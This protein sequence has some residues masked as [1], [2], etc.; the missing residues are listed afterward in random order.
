MTGWLLAA[1]A[2][3]SA[4]GIAFEILLMRL[5]SI[6]QWHHFAAMTISIAMLGF[7]ASG[8]FLAVARPWAIAHFGAIWRVNA[9]LFG[10]TAIGAFA[11]IQLLP[12]NPM[13]LAWNLELF[14]RLIFVYLLAMVP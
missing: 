8:T 10:V 4:G 12:I 2:I 14:G 3:I 11:L 5:N 13:E 9:V 7:G 1:I 6:A